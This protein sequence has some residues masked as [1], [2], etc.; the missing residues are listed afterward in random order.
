MSRPRMKPEDRKP[1]ARRKDIAKTRE[2]KDPSTE[3]GHSGRIQ[4][5]TVCNQTGRPKKGTSLT[6]LLR[7]RIEDELKMNDGSKIAIKK[8]IV[9]KKLAAVINGDSAKAATQQN[10]DW[11]FDRLD[12]KP[13]QPVEQTIQEMPKPVSEEDAMKAAQD[14]EKAGEW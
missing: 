4:P 8:L 12:G 5:G 6:E 2:L 10:I 13:V 14:A 9:E 11:I 1:R 7:A 3:R